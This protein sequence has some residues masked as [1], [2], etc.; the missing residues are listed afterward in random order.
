VEVEG[1]EGT[2]VVEG[3]EAEVHM[4]EEIV[5]LEDVQGQGA[6]N[7]VAMIVA[8]QHSVVLLVSLLIL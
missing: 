1:V 6:M 7:V 3:E 2:A 5:T 4:G 8:H